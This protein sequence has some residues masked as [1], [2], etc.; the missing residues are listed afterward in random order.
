M[1]HWLLVRFF[2]PVIVILS[3]IFPQY[4]EK[5]TSFFVNLN[6]RLVKKKEVILK[7]TEQLLILLPQCLQFADCPHKITKNILN[8]H[9]CGKCLIADLVHL[10]EKYNLKINVATGGRLAQRLV[11][12]FKPNAIV[13][14]ACEHELT[15]GIQAVYPLPVLGILN[16]RPYGP[17]LNTGVDLNKIEQAV[18]TFLG[19]EV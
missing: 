12:D 5:Y 7:K 15:D 6:N 18:K 2:Y 13:A 3:K 8:C 9:Q 16:T 19:G 11:S 14:C 10:G 4:E 17:C 1:R